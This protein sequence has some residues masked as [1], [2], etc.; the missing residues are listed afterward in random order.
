MPP[1]LTTRSTWDAASP[2]GAA[3][4]VAVTIITSA[5]VLE[6]RG[7][8]IDFPLPD[9]RWR[10]SCR[11]RGRGARGRRRRREPAGDRALEAED[12]L[13]CGIDLLGR[14]RA[15]ALGPGLDV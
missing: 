5:S 12:V 13:G 3:A 14:H 8:T 15:D 2:R 6:K 4:R 9:G 1:G 11:G 7:L 10:R